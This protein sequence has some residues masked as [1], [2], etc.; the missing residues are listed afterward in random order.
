MLTRLSDW[1]RSLAAFTAI[2]R[3]VKRCVYIL[4]SSSRRPKGENGVRREGGRGGGKE[5]RTARGDTSGEEEK[6]GERGKKSRVRFSDVCSQGSVNTLGRLT[7]QE[8]ELAR[9][10]KQAN[11]LPLGSVAVGESIPRVSRQS[12]AGCTLECGDSGQV[13]GAISFSLRVLPLGGERRDGW[14]C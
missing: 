2:Y 14:E 4:Q 3:E 11:A 7:N 6:A 9:S 13:N 8:A 1:T 12:A 10:G 5:K